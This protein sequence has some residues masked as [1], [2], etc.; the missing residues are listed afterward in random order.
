MPHSIQARYDVAVPKKIVPGIAHPSM[1]RDVRT[2]ESLNLHRQMLKSQFA[3]GTAIDRNEMWIG[4]FGTGE[5]RQQATDRNV[6][7]GPAK[8]IANTMVRSG[9]EGEDALRV[10]MDI[11]MQRIGKDIRIVVRGFRGRP[12]HPCIYN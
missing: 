2:W 7:S 10:A 11:E 3:D 12:P 6:D 9:A 1:R 8:D 4:K 5:S